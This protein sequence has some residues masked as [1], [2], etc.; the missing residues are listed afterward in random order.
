MAMADTKAYMAFL[1]FTLCLNAAMKEATPEQKIALREGHEERT[2]AIKERGDLQ[3]WVDHIKSV[4]GADWEPS[5]EDGE[6]IRTMLE[7]MQ[8]ADRDSDR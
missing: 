1:A 6:Y 7:S 2:E 5:G 8:E 4:M 3:P